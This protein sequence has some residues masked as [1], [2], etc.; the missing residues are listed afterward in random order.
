MTIGYEQHVKS[1]VDGGDPDDPYPVPPERA[2]MSAPDRR[3]PDLDFAPGDDIA[4]IA[5][6]LI[7][8]HTWRRF[9]DLLSLERRAVLGVA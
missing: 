9:D 2:F 6:W 1:L 7:N 5:G 3:K 4:R 8:A